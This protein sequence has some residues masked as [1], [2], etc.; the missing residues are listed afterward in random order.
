MRVSE[1]V[2]IRRIVLDMFEQGD[3]V[4]A[5]WLV[6]QH[7]EAMELSTD[8]P[9]LVGEPVDLALWALRYTRRGLIVSPYIRAEVGQQNRLA[10]QTA[11]DA[12]NAAGGGIIHIPAGYF[13]ISGQIN[14]TGGHDIVFMGA[15]QRVT[16]LARPPLT[17]FR[18]PR[19]TRP[20]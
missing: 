9:T 1:A 20:A 11:V 16:T 3:V 8:L 15:P 18:L 7:P 5:I 13:E 19:R 6:G 2:E 4:L 10:M 12:A 17:P 14:C